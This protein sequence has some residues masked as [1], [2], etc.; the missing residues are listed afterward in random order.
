MVFRQGFSGVFDRGSTGV[1][2]AGPHL[3][4]A[5][6]SASRQTSAPGLVVR[7]LGLACCWRLGWRW[8]GAVGDSTRA[9]GRVSTIPSHP[10]A[11]I[12]GHGRSA[13]WY[14]L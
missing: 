10:S 6:R 2:G 8:L 13:G 11:L 9:V 3:R 1:V 4:A 5:V 12:V 14:P 7:G